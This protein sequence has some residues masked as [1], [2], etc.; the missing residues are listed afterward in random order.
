M[1]KTF[2]EHCKEQFDALP[3]Y[4]H[5]LF[6]SIQTGLEMM[7]WSYCYGSEQTAVTLE[8]DKTQIVIYRNYSP[9]YSEPVST[10]KIR[11]SVPPENDND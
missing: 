7:G 6:T 4:E 11:Y 5:E 10:I 2:S 8:K 1:A 9:A 3:Q